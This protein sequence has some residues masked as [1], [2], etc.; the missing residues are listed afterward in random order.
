LLTPGSTVPRS[1]DH[2]DD[3]KTMRDAPGVSWRRKVP[4][5]L[6]VIEDVAEVGQERAPVPFHVLVPAPGARRRDGGAPR[7]A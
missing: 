1:T 7:G 6:A 4:L 5:R 3:A 2:R